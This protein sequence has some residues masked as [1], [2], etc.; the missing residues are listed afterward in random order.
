MTVRQEA[1]GEEYGGRLDE[2][3]STP[4]MPLLS[5]AIGYRMRH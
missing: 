2:R 4:V 3:D 5:L 1:S